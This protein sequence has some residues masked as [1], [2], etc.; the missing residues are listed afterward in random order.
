MKESL[1]IRSYLFSVM[2]V[3]NETGAIQPIK[4]ACALTKRAAK[5]ALF[6]IATWFRASESFAKGQKNLGADLI[7]ISGHKVHAPKRNRGPL[8]Q[9]WRP[10]KQAFFSAEDRKKSPLGNRKSS[11]PPPRSELLFRKSPMRHR[12]LKK[13]PPFVTGSKAVLKNRR[14]CF[15]FAERRAALHSEFFPLR[16]SVGGYDTLSRGDEHFCFGRQRLFKGR[17]QP[18]S[19]GAGTACRNH[20][21]RREGQLST[22]TT[23]EQVD[24]LCLAVTSAS[25]ILRR[26]KDERNHTYK[27][28][29][30]AL[31]GQNRRGFEE[32][33]MKNIRRRI[34]PLGEADVHAAQS[35]VY[36]EPKDESFDTAEAAR[37]VSKIFGIAAYTP[38]PSP[39]RTWTA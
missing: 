16:R 39:K 5:N 11:P 35:T 14:H 24:E 17:A 34:K 31:K 37:R 23:T 26:K 36:I 1:T 33:L 8:C 2:A 18:C 30:L 25:K 27:N 19:R 4:E 28:G 21:Q 12:L 22:D 3:N 13:P 38:P 20:R 15:Q 29:E 10:H 7:S 32:T 9:K 6:S